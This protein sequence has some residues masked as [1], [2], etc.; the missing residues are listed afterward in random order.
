MNKRLLLILI[1]FLLFIFAL[2]LKAIMPTAL[3]DSDGNQDT[4]WL[5]T[6][7]AAS[8]DGT[9]HLSGVNWRVSGDS[10]GGAYM[11]VSPQAPSDSSNGCCCTYFPCVFKD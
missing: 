5:V 4:I 2:P 8:K 1:I 9:Y 3:A 6:K 11:L 10:A 7:S